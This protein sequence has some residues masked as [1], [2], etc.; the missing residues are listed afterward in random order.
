[1][2]SL[3]VIYK[4]SSSVWMIYDIFASWFES[5]FVPS[6]RHRLYSKKLEERALLGLD[7]YPAHENYV[8]AKECYCPNSSNGLG[9]H[10]S[11]F[12]PAK[13]IITVS[14]LLKF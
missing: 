9:H 2:P 11:L 4:N 12:E 6:V 7:H 8:S 5:E 1:M 10:L 14:S 13:P 3:P